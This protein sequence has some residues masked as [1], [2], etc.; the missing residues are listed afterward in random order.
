MSAEPVLR[1]AGRASGLGKR[2]KNLFRYFKT[3]SEVI[4]E[5]T[6]QQKPEFLL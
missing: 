5:K 4:R 1:R 3:S 2:A 6:V